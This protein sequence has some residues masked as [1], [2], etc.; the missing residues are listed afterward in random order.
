MDLNFSAENTD[1]YQISVFEGQKVTYGNPALVNRFN[2]AFLKDATI[3]V[4]SNTYDADY[5]GGGG[6]KIISNNLV[7]SNPNA[8]L[9]AINIVVNNTVTSLKATETEDMPDTEKIHTANIK[10]ISISNSE[11]VEAD[12]EIVPVETE[13]SEG[14]SLRI[15]IIKKSWR[16]QCHY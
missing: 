14:L 10:D 6:G 13:S 9:G 5:C 1:K 15:P 16:N 3:L 7:K 11:V 12:I 8:I 4:G 2:V